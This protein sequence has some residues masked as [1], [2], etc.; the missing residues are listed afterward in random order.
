MSIKGFIKRTVPFF[1]T[2][3]IGLFVASFFVTVSAPS[4]QFNRGWKKHRQYHRTME[5]ENQRLREENFRL[6]REL[7]EKENQNFTLSSDGYEVPPPP[8]SAPR[9]VPYRR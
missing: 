9:A 4:F 6:K 7:V 5:F 3:A 1:L 2:F 8:A